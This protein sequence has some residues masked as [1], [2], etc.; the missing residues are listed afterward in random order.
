MTRFRPCIDLH[1]GKVKQIVGG[2]L[3]DSGEALK[4]NFVSEHASAWFAELYRRDGLTGGHVI[5]LGLGNDDAA[6][7]ALKTYPQGLQMG[8]GINLANAEKY[9]QAGASHVIV[10]SWIF[11]EGQLDLSRLAQLSSS[12][13]KS[14][15]VLD[16]SCRRKAQDWFVTTNRWQTFTAQALTSE[17]FT[18]LAAYC[19][20]FL[21]HAADVEGQC[22]GIDSEL[23][24]FLGSACP[25]PVTYAGGAQDLSDLNKVQ[26][27][28]HGKVDLTIGS[29]LDIFGGS[30]IKY[31]DCVNYN[32]QQK[33]R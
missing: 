15:L 13:G 10:T 30:L 24:S 6:L 32:S 19:N 21:I 16:L 28:S 4:T 33:S 2:S 1:Q 5:A 23:V 11:P 8:G 22:K 25:L 14:K 9:L 7:E 18:E 12:I 31:A 26:Q 3:T 20:E 17:L 27:L 29:A